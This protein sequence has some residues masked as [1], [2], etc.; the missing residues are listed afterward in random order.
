[1][2]RFGESGRREH[3]EAVLKEQRDGAGYQNCDVTCI[4]LCVQTIRI[5]F[6]GLARY[7]AKL[8]IINIYPNVLRYNL[9][10]GID[11]GKERERL[12]CKDIRSINYNNKE[13]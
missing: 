4:E 2:I 10:S 1:M 3:C 6:G 9:A 8:I 11:N 12:P 5:S 7:A 13:T